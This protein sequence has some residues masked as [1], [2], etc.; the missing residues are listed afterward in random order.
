MLLDVQRQPGA[1]IVGTVDAVRAELPELTRALPPGIH[2]ELAADRTA[3]IRASVSDVQR[4]LLLSRC[5][6]SW[7]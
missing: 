5:C 3:T 7:A 4:T 1:N 6:S 2:M